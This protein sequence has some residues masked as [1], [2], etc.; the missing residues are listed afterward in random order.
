MLE[1][2]AAFQELQTK[3]DDERKTFE[4]IIADA[5]ETHNMNV[6]NM[7]DKHKAHMDAQTAVTEQLKQEIES[8]KQDFTEVKGQILQDA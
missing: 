6:N 8:H 1:D 5:I 2:A 7:M 4:E 3:K